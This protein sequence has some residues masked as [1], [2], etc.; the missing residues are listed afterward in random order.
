VILGIKKLKQN[1]VGIDVVLKLQEIAASME[2]AESLPEIYK[3]I[4]D[5]AHRILGFDRINVLIVSDDGKMLQCQEARGNLDEPV[6]SIRC[7]TDKRGGAIAKA[8]NEKKTIWVPDSSKPLPPDYALSDPFNKIK[9]FRSRSFVI[10]PLVSKGKAIG[11]IGVDNKFKKRP[12]TKD[13]VNI[14]DLFS[15]QAAAAIANVYFKNRSQKLQKKTEKY[16]NEI[17]KKKEEYEEIV[18]SVSKEIKEV[19]NILLDLTKSSTELLKQSEALKSQYQTISEKLG[20]I[21]RITASIKDVAMQTRLLA[22]NAAIEAARS[23]E[24]GKGF[25]VVAEEIRKL[26]QKSTEESQGIGETLEGIR[27]GIEEVSASIIQVS[28]VAH[29]MTKETEKVKKGVGVIASIMRTLKEE[30][31]IDSSF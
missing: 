19:S 28:G 8:F 29:E 2:E 23:G 15:K 14:L 11:V 31:S 21:D 20:E 16:L 18:K 10:V 17:E 5:G 4:A 24:A 3:K 25:A 6:D 1:P 27:K 12:I 7:P 26:A 9:A 30:K 13:E 22:L